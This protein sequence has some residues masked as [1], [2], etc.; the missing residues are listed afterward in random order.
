[1]YNAHCSLHFHSI[2]IDNVCNPIED[3]VT[4]HGP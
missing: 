3:S 2:K 1:M 4:G